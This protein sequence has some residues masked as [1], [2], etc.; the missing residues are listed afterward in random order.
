MGLVVGSSAGEVAYDKSHQALTLD[1]IQTF[2]QRQ[3]LH[4]SSGILYI[5]RWYRHKA[6]MQAVVYIQ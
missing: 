5:V 3:C 4:A 6:S 1:T 2:T